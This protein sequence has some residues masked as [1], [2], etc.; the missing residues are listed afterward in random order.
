[1]FNGGLSLTSGVFIVYLWAMVIIDWLLEGILWIYSN[2]FVSSSDEMARGSSH[3]SLASDF[4]RK[5]II[6]INYFCSSPV[7]LRIEK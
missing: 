5:H 3:S 7:D 2:K 1:M 4:V 6:K